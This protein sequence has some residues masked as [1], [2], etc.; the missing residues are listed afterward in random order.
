MINSINGN[1]T[2]Y[3]SWLE[4]L[5]IVTLLM[6]GLDKLLAV[7]FAFSV[8]APEIIL[9]LLSLVGGF[10]G[11]WLGMFLF[12]HKINGKKHPLFKPVLILSTAIHS[13]LF[14]FLIF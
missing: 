12:R 1:A 3:I 8:R 7:Q 11:G 6:Y 2:F 10:P 14:Y 13:V 4:T 9:H 5:S